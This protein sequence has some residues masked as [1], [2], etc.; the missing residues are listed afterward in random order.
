VNTTRRTPAYQLA[1]L[2]WLEAFVAIT[3]VLTA[4]GP[5]SVAHVRPRAI[6]IVPGHV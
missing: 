3:A 2:T 4:L 6:G 5:P 1:L